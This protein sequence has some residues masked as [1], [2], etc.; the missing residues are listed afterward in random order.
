MRYHWL[1]FIPL[2]G[3]AMATAQA[4]SPGVTI[5]GLNST[6]LPT[7]ASEVAYRVGSAPPLEARSS[8]FRFVNDRQRG[9]LAQPPPQAMDRAVV[10]GIERGWVGGRPPLECARTPMNAACH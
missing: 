4:T 10:L 9:V 6:A 5:S 1:A 3:L 7:L 8:P 2:L